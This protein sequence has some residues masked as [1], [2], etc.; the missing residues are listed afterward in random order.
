MYW[1]I[2]WTCLESLSCTFIFF[3]SVLRKWFNVIFN[4]NNSPS[5]CLLSLNTNHV[6]TFGTIHQ[7]VRIED[8]LL[9]FFVLHLDYCWTNKTKI[10]IQ[11]HFIRIRQR[12]VEVELTDKISHV[13]MIRRGFYNWNK[14]FMDINPYWKV[15]RMVNWYKKSEGSFLQHKSFLQNVGKFAVSNGPQKIHTLIF[16]Q[17]GQNISLSFRFLFICK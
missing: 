8:F 2:S 11:F 17:F 9:S 15:I 16:F 10:R 5:L 12:D 4:L 3:N 1:S 13:L 6:L 7:T 14:W